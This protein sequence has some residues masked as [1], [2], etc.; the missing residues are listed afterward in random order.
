MKEGGR[1]ITARL[2]PLYA[3]A[4]S[5]RFGEAVG[6]VLLGNF[7]DVGEKLCS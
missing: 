3:S 2:P 7:G 4:K 5:L 1:S 6:T